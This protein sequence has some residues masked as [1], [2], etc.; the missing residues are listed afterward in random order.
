[1][2]ER[3][4]GPMIRGTV[5]PLYPT[6][7]QAEMIEKNIEGCK[8]I[9]NWG[10]DVRLN[11]LK[12]GKDCGHYE[13]CRMLTQLKKTEKY[14]YLNELDSDALQRSLSHLDRGMQMFYKGIFGMP[15]LKDEKSKAS[16][17]T[18]NKKGNIRIEGNCIRIPKIGPVKIKLTREVTDIKYITISRTSNGKYTV[19]INE[20][21]E[22]DVMPLAKKATGI[23]MGLDRYYTN[24]D[25]EYVDNPKWFEKSQKKL[26]RENRR[27]ARKQKGSKNRE[28]QRIKLSKV[29]E[30][31]SNQR[32]DFQHKESR[33]LV[34]ENQTICIEDL[35]IKSMLQNRF[36]S[37]G[38]S[39]AGWGRFRTMLEYKGRENG[40][41]IIA[42]ST[43][44]PSS[45]LCSGCGYR[46]APA[47]N[48]AIKK[49]I[50]PNCGAVHDRDQNAAINILRKGLQ[51]K[52]A[53]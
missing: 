6:R 19:S 31:I 47:K 3:I 37:R 23:D 42:V 41:D 34:R 17:Q 40:S 13:A 44:Y 8:F 16:Y 51:M 52:E 18:Y 15:K 2:A 9:F 27:L 1:M 46:Y 45:Q 49:W 26:A 10:L 32:K 28:K 35:A 24:Q 21:Y 48:P 7:E 53:E 33:K 43:Y 39:H 30:K 25:G 14:S 11:S 38:I 20:E 5:F 12:A 29:T 22:P 36:Y 4:D 50:C